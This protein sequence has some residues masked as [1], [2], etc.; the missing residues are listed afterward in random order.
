MSLNKPNQSPNVPHAFRAAR[1]LLEGIEAA[2]AF[3]QAHVKPAQL[4]VHGGHVEGVGRVQH[5]ALGDR[6]HHRHRHHH[7]VSW[8]HRG[9]TQASSTESTNDGPFTFISRSFSRRFYPK[10]LK[11]STLVDIQYIAVGTVRC[12]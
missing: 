2:G 1:Y 4:Q 7:H 8:T 6:T 11:I 5:T 10:R 9:R 12:S 3:L